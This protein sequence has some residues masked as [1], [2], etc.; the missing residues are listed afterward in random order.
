[1]NMNEKKK[2]YYLSPGKMISIEITEGLKKINDIYSK[3]KDFPKYMRETQDF[4]GLDEPQCTTEAQLFLGGFLEGEASLNLS[5][6]KQ[7][8]SKFGIVLDPEFSITQHINGVKHLYNALAIFKTGRIRYKS[9]SNAT[10]V[11]TIDNRIS[12]EDKVIPFYERYVVPYAAPS[13]CQRLRTFTKVVKLFK[14]NAHHDPEQFINLMLPLWDDLRMQKG[15]SNQSFASLREAQDYAK[16][17]LNT[18][19]I[20]S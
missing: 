2:P 15:Q 12:L 14:K 1:M 9:G 17:F 20:I 5:A 6:K 16:K 8:N 11:F 19:Q 3:S 10:L 7:Q 4:F 13:K 18:K